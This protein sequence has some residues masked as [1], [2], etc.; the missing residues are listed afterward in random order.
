[1]NEKKLERARSRVNHYWFWYTRHVAILAIKIAFFPL[2]LTVAG[3][4]HLVGL[5]TV[6]DRY[7]IDENQLDVVKHP[8]EYKAVMQA[9]LDYY[10]QAGANNKPHKRRFRRRKHKSTKSPQH[11]S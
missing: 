5:L 4:Q 6:L 3:L 11:A 2:I 10:N 9:R 1:M 7:L 8:L